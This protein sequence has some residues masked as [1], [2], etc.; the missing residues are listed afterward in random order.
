MAFYSDGLIDIDKVK[1]EDHYE[2]SVFEFLNSY[3]VRFVPEFEQTR[4]NKGVLFEKVICIPIDDSAFELDLDDDIDDEQSP[5]ESAAI[6]ARLTSQ[7]E[8]G[9]GLETSQGVDMYTYRVSLKV[10]REV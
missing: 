5:Q 4:L 2:Y 3:G 8:V 1:M 6:Q 9:I 10:G 7:D